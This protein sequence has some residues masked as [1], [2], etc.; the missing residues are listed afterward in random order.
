[1]LIASPSPGDG[2]TTIATNLARALARHGTTCIVDADV[3]RKAVSSAFGMASRPGLADAIAGTARLED[4]LVSV[5]DVPGL[6]VLSAGNVGE[7]AADVLVSEETRNVLARLRS[8]FE[9]V[10][11]DSP[12]ILPY[13]EGRALAVLSDGV[14]LV[15]R[16]RATTRDALNRTAQVLAEARVRILGF[17]LNGADLNAPDYR[18]YRYHDYERSA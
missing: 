4:V 12:P 16:Y 6:C 17:V 14:I 9:F 2:K 11:L 1:M 5:P 15:G 8:R 10:V 18:L 13:A 3:R 7:N